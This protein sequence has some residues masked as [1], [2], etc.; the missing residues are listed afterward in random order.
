MNL[1]ELRAAYDDEQR[2]NAHYPDTQR[3]AAGRA[4]RYVQT[5]GRRLGWV[6]WPDLDE[7]TVEEAIDEQIAFFAD[8]VASFEW[9]V[10]SYGRPPDP[11]EVR[12]CLHRAGDGLP[13][14]GKRGR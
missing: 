7:T 10:Y 13:L 3:D 6:L 8:K 14:A 1:T 2:L 9:K 4:I 11:G 5:T 12:L